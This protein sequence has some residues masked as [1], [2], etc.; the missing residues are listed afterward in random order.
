MGQ[1]GEMARSESMGAPRDENGKPDLGKSFIGEEY[2]VE[3]EKN[4][5]V[6]TETKYRYHPHV[7][8]DKFLTPAPVEWADNKDYVV[9]DAALGALHLVVVARDKATG[10]LHVFSSGHNQYGQL[11]HGDEKSRHKLTRIQSLDKECIIQVACGEAFTFFR[12]ILGTVFACGRSEDGRLGLSY[13]P[14]PW[15]AFGSS[16]SGSKRSI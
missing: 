16:T 2:T 3:V 15:G 11:G 1:S 12:S 5:E 7:I 4:G 9:L 14:A 13:V 6:K 8:L 10:A